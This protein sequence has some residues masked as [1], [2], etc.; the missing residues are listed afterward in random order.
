MSPPG[1]ERGPRYR[2]PASSTSELSHDVTNYFARI[3][4]WLLEA[5]LSHG[6]VR[7]YGILDRGCGKDHTTFPSRTTLARKMACNRTTV[8]RFIVELV[9]VGAVE[10]TKRWDDAGDP[11]TNL[12]YLVARAQLPSR[13]DATTPLH[14]CDDGGPT[15]ATT[16][17]CTDATQNESHLEREP[18][19]CVLDLACS[20]LNT[21]ARKQ[22]DE[23]RVKIRA[24]VAAFG[25]K[26]VTTELTAMPDECMPFAGD[27]Y[28]ALKAHLEAHKAPGCERCGDTGQTSTGFPCGCPATPGRRTA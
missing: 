1:A 20:K 22:H 17:S 21:P 10:V 28:R 9:E 16:G 18:L 13:T 3:P 11:T 4:E 23:A 14:G 27:L 2:G 26:A 8:D 12:Y 24:L 15:D 19:E 25:E 6:A 5:E 7:L